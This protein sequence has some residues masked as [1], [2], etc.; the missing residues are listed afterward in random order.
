MCS[1]YVLAHYLHHLLKY[2]VFFEEI[3]LNIDCLNF[4]RSMCFSNV[5][6][7]F[8]DKIQILYIVLNHFQLNLCR[9]MKL[10]T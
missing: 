7:F 6:D 9:V 3:I 8:L 10:S 2:V 1:I 4:Y 5:Y